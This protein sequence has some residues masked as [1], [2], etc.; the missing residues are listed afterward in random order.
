MFGFV[1]RL[2]MV[3]VLFASFSAYASDTAHTQDPKDHEFNVNIPTSFTGEFQE[4][5]TDGAGKFNLYVSGSPSSKGAIL[6]I[7]EWWGLNAHI[8]GMADQLGRLG[9][10]VYAVDLYD[11]KVTDDAKQAGELMSAGDPGKSSAKLSATLGEISKSYD[12]IGT[13]GWSFGGGWSL[14]A[15]LADP[16]LVDATVIYYGMLE[17]DPK[18]LGKLKGP[19]L[20]IFASKDGWITK[21]QVLD[22]ED[23]L[24]EAKVSHEVISYDAD[25]AFADP[26]GYRFE[27]ASARDAWSKT[28]K[29]LAENLTK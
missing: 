8:K 16:S 2:L 10:R 17:S 13:I 26:S 15:S 28:L 14:L 18:I 12:K 21:K 7:H 24:K 19:V 6:M 27:E 22:F 20:G 9:Y 25:H 1:S 11:G 29:F 4:I 23:G 5:E 3:F